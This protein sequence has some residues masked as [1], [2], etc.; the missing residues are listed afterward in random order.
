M[1]SIQ[2]QDLGVRCQ[3]ACFDLQQNACDIA[4]VPSWTEAEIS[5]EI[6]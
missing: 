3:R 6:L 2:A 1:V 5:L 4:L